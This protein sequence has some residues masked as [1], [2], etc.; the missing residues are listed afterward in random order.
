[1]GSVLSVADARE[2]DELAKLESDYQNAIQE[3]NQYLSDRNGRV[4]DAAEV[5][6]IIEDPALLS[7]V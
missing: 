4:L 6:L 1:V 2:A 3:M 5:E 7:V